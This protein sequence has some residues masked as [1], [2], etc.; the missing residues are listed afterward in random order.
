MKRYKFLA[1]CLGIFLALLLGEVIMRFY[2]FNK[3]TA[4]NLILSKNKKLIYEHKPSINFINKYGIR[5]RYNSLGLIGS[6]IYEKTND[7]FRIL[8]IGDSITEAPYLPENHSYLNRLAEELK[9]NTKRRIEV[10][11]AAVGGYNTWQELE[12]MKE[13]SLLVK[14]DLIIVGVCLNDFVDRKPILKKSWFNRIKVNFQ[15]GS[16]ARYFNFLYQ[17]SSLYKFLYDFLSHTRRK[18]LGETGYRRYLEEYNFDISRSDFEKWKKPFEE[19]M[20]F[21]KENKIKILFVIFPLH[22]QILHK[23]ISSYSPLSDFFK[24]KNA[25]FLD[26]MEDF[27]KESEEGKSLFRKRDIIHPTSLGHSIAAE[28]IS[29]S[30]IQNKLLNK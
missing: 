4:Q 16:K 21:S 14:T 11:N 17:K 9:K 28:A 29:N 25:N 8:G 5:V 27:K 19:M 1:I 10:M 26:L 18:G 7:T 24:Q 22:N 15:D 13:K 30:I 23:E 3:M 12:M 2:Y 6:E 20:I